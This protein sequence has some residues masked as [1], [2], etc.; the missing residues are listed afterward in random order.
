MANELADGQGQL[1]HL[2]RTGPDLRVRHRAQALLLVAQGQSVSAVAWLFTTME[3]C[4]RTWRE[5]FLAEGRAGLLDRPRRGRPPQLDAA[6]AFLRQAGAWPAAGD[7][8]ALLGLC[9]CGGCEYG[10]SAGAPGGRNVLWPSQRTSRM[11]NV[12]PA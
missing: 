11:V 1:H 7:G 12:T 5:R 6:R 8:H 3:H 9:V 2:T 4:V 10:V